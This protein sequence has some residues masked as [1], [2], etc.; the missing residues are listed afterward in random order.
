M[1]KLN[2]QKQRQRLQDLRGSFELVRAKQRRDN[3]E[4]LHE[5]RLS[6]RDRQLFRHLGIVRYLT[7]DQVRR[8]AFI[9]RVKQVA[10]ERLR[11]LSGLGIHPFPHPPLRRLVFQTFDGRL[12][13]VW[14]LS[15]FGYALVQRNASG[16]FEAPSHPDV[17]PQFLEHA[18]TLNELYVGLVEA[19]LTKKAAAILS[20]LGTHAP[21]AERRKKLLGLYADAKGA[22]FRWIG[23]DA[24]ALPWSEYDLKAG[25]TRGRLIEPD[26][27]LEFPSA[28]RRWFVECEMGTQPIVSSRKDR[29]GAT[30]A[31]AERY[32]KFLSSIADPHSRGTFY[33]KEFPDGWPV[34]VLFLVQSA[35]REASVNEAI[36]EWRGK[37]GGQ[38]RI[39]AVAQMLP[40]ALAELLPL[41]G[42][43][44]PAKP[45]VLKPEEFA[46][47]RKFY[48]ATADAAKKARDAARAL[49]QVPPEYAEGTHEAQKVIARLFSQVK[50]AS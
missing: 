5:R 43:R 28:E 19:P 46:S 23:E 21:P 49:G 37:R 35:S 31:K 25:E 29:Y 32:E 16:K 1:I 22:P 10:S 12:V 40:K 14:T 33:A 36:A 47:L 30:I 6:D 11:A 20:S 45:L 18:V 38:T 13:S 27:T 4:G 3:G 39:R 2:K 42:V 50:D 26:A 24:G 7:T 34:T 17:S 15:S 8:L 48:E 9:G 44:A 41:V